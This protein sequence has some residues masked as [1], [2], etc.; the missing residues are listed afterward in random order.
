MSRKGKIPVS[1]IFK[2]I[3]SIQKIDRKTLPHAEKNLLISI[4]IHLGENDH[5]WPTNEQMGERIGESKD[6]VK[7]LIMRLKNKKY[8][9]IEGRYKSRKIY[10]NEEKIIGNSQL[11]KQA[12]GNSQLPN[13]NPELPP[14][15]KEKEKKNIK[16]KL[17]A[18]PNSIYLNE[19]MKAIPDICRPYISRKFM[20][21]CLNAKNNDRPYFLWLFDRCIDKPNPIKWL[22]KGM[23]DYYPKYLRSDDYQAACGLAEFRSMHGN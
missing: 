7:N 19:M 2:V 21:E 1:N 11:P 9:K 18:A 12:N 15:I 14:Y 20:N 6:Y 13:G 22:S 23:R 16:E 3:K 10:L 8:I 17:G 5:I 4:A